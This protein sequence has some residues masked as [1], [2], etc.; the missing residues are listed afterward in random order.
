MS[1]RDQ[2][3]D[4][5][6]AELQPHDVTIGKK[7]KQFFFR[8]VS[9]EEGRTIFI[10]VDGE[11]DDVRG[12]RI[13]VGLISASLCDAEGVKLSTPDEVAALPSAVKVALFNKAAITNNLETDDKPDEAATDEAADSPKG[14]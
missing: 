11:A 2:L 8:Q 10:P 4:L 12:R 14:G 5:I 9:D 1:L 13:M 6:G 7:S 3:L